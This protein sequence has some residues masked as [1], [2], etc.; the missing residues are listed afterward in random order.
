MGRNENC[1]KSVPCFCYGSHCNDLQR[2][3]YAHMCIYLYKCIYIYIYLYIYI[4]I[5]IALENV[6]S[7][8]LGPRVHT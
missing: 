8:D 7:L 6:A 1:L 2:F 3:T 5:N 4:Y